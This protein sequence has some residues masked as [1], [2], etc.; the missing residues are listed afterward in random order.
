MLKFGNESK[1]KEFFINWNE[2]WN[3][4]GKMGNDG[5][6]IPNKEHLEKLFMRKPGLPILKVR[7]PDGSKQPYWNTFYQEIKYQKISSKNLHSKIGKNKLN[8]KDVEVITNLVNTQIENNRDL[9]EINFNGYSNFKYEVI[10]YVE[11]NR[12][13]LGQ[14]DLN[15]KSPLVWEF[16]DSTFEKLNEYGCK[17]VRLDAFAYLHKEPG[18]T[19]FFNKPGTWEYLSKIRK[20]AEKHN[21]ILLP[22]IHSIYGDGLH[23][24]VAREGYPIYDFFFPGLVIHAIEWGTNEFLVNWIEEILENNIQTVNML[25]CHDGI[26]LLDLKGEKNPSKG[27]KGLLSDV[28]IDEIVD[29][30]LKRGGR[31]KNLFGAEGKKITYYQINATFFSALGEDEQKLLLARAI[32]MFMPGIPQIWYLDLFAGKNDYEAADKGGIAGHKEINRTSLTNKGIEEGLKRL[33]VKAQLKLLK[34][35]NTLSAFEG[36]LI[37]S[38]SEKHILHLT[39][40]YNEL[41]VTLTADL[42]SHEFKII[43]KEDS[44]EEK[45]LTF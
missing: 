26:P 43:Y 33:I 36:E 6:I 5:Y 31:I 30:I 14:M 28:Q 37:I 40:E 38:K 45:N 41:F 25:G 19:N 4:N 34:L 15:A 7:F 10:S 11:Q 3:S 17:L 20:L 27:V 44:G 24:E 39:W 8:I 18:K 22:E 16:Y 29:L 2:F 13:Y 12:N 42:R 21:L 35:R 1:F 32:Q 9:N 23:K